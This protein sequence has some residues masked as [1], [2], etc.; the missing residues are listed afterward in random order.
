MVNIGEIYKELKKLKSLSVYKNEP[1][2]RHTTIKTGGPA[3]ILLVPKNIETL[4]EALNIT[5]GIKKYIIG[6][7]SNILVADKG[8]NGIVI[9]IAGGMNDFEN[10][11][12]FVTAGAGILLQ[13]LIHRHTLLGLSGLEYAA[14]VPAA[15]GGAIATN[16]G[17]FGHDI[18]SLIEYVD[19][20]DESG[21]RE[22][23]CRSDISFSYRK[24]N[25]RNCIITSVMLKLTYKR[26]HVIKRMIKEFI[27]KRRE[28]QPISV[29]SAGS[30]FKNPK[31]V[32]AGKLIDMAGCK[33]LRIGGAEVSKKHA[34]F[35]IN[36]GDAK[37]GDIIKLINKVRSIVKSKFNVNLELELIDSNQLNMIF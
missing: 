28:L 6:N 13:N 2:S 37:S 17:A 36:L 35:I 24:S 8:V 34:N 4:Q 22:K 23:L 12:R 1:L 25:I 21:K 5:R 10:N 15:L 33:G 3:D 19:I 26:K 18:G 31:D 20:I 29:P 9:K 30:V 11:G 16:M 14:W 7:G 27:S 32:P